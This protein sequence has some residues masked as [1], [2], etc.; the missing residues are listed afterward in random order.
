MTQAPPPTDSGWSAAPPPAPPATAGA[1]SGLITAAGITLIVLGALTLLLGLFL[2]L[3]VALFAGSAGSV[4]TE[5]EVPGVGGMLGA[6]AGIFLVLLLIVIAFGGL[7]LFSGI[8]VLSGRPW[9]RVTGIVVGV[10]GAIFALAGLGG[11]DSGGGSI[12]ISLALAA[13]N[14]FVVFALATGGAWFRDRLA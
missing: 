11:Q 4:P 9:A 8:K 14:A 7:Q 13:A 3:G 6:F 5:A 2:L 10:I 1:R 12:V